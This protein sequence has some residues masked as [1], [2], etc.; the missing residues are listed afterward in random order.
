MISGLFVY[1][2]V[3]PTPLVAFFGPLQALGL[4][5]FFAC[6]LA[7]KGILW[8]ERRKN[9]KFDSPSANRRIAAKALGV[10]QGAVGMAFLFSM[11]ATALRSI[12]LPS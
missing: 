9:V 8:W 2:L 12:S 11:V 7:L 5:L 3:G 6:D 4:V 1:S 10:F